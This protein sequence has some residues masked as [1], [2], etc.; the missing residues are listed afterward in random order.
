MSISKTEEYCTCG[1]LQ[2]A[3]ETTGMPVKFDKDMNEFLL[4]HGLEGGRDLLMRHCFFCG[5]KAPEALR[6][7]LF[8]RLTDEERWR[9]IRLTQD[10]KTVDDT[11]AALGEPD[12][13]RQA[14]SSNTYP[15]RD[16]KPEETIYHRTLSYRNLSQTANVHV[17]VYPEGQVAFSFRGKRLSKEPNQM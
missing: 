15:E 3:A 5:G 10:L 17:T 11:I 9:L 13:D 12:S 6:A 2:R 14:G 4:L 16:G 1:S 8:E 7:S